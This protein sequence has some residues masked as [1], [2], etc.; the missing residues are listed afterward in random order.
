MRTLYG[1]DSKGD[2]R[3]WSIY[4]EG[5]EVVVKH[6]KL[7]GKVQEKRYTTEGKNQGKSN[8]TTPE[9]Q[10]GLE[11]EA[12]YAKQLKSGYFPDKDDALGYIEFTPQKAHNYN[13]QA[14][15]IVY[16]CLGQKKLDGCFSYNT[17][18]H[19]SEGYMPIGDIVKNKLDIKVA[20]FN[21]ETEKVE[22]KRVTNWFNNGMK[23]RDEW[24]LFNK[25]QRITKNHKVYS[26][27]EW[28]AASDAN[29]L[30]GVNPKFN[31]IV[32]GMLLGDSVASIEKRKK[33]TGQY[34][35]WRLSYSVS[36]S[37]YGFGVTKSKLLSGITWK[38]ANRISGYGKPQ[39]AFTSCAL[40]Q[41]PF[42][43]SIFYELDRTSPDYGRRKPIDFKKLKE[44]FTDESLT[45]WYMDD[46]SISYNNGNTLTP[47]ITI[48]V[49]RYNKE[50]VEGFAKLF[51]DK[52][53]TLPSISY[54]KDHATLTFS[55]IDTWYL[56]SRMARCA[57][58][59]CVR[60]IPDVFKLSE[61]QT[62]EMYTEVE[63]HIGT[64]YGYGSDD[65]FYEAFD[66][67][68][69]DNHNYFAE[70]VLVHNCR[71]M[72]DKNGQA[73]SK[74]GEPIELPAH[75]VGVKELAINCGSLDGEVYAG[76]KNQGGLSLQRIISAFRK[77]NEDTHKLQYWV[78]DIPNSSTMLE[79]SKTIEFLS[80]T[81]PPCVVLVHGVILKNE[82][83]ADQFFEAKVNQGYEGVVYRNLDA[84]YE[85]G[86][87][88]YNLIKR[89]PR[90][91]SEA[92]VISVEKDRNS[93]GILSCKTFE[94]VEFKCQMRVDAADKNYR[95]YENALE[96][97]GQTI[98][99]EF[100]ELSDKNVPT[101]PSGVGLREVD[102]YG[103]PLA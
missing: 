52:Y 10:A 77:P 96:L 97:I 70:G 83:D 43:L 57:E 61:I 35:S 103:R 88:S 101:K 84:K 73:W 20:S 82:N 78:Y 72:I 59:M 100:E 41:S 46:G 42:D 99:Y 28:V 67:E 11:A 17:K 19:T 29:G 15:K 92:V 18:I 13:D 79:R 40:S 51:K 58:G 85:F 48:S 49:A 4:T 5:S 81:V 1:K 25:K 22:F 16:P 39:K 64:C 60:K 12:K 3:V 9:Q 80:K 95:L 37:D 26:E 14:H 8:E 21:E 56:F 2:L 50:T 102:K 54:H 30:F 47:R 63:S 87:R 66:I 98:E 34:H 68:V 23:P 44:V 53:N 45:I 71:L 93:W 76:L 6:G 62:V 27:G 91:T 74:Q 24:L 31:A 38:E 75:W 69:E 90:D 65:S 94:G 89:K 55:T 86:K 7:G 36:E 33:S 32:A